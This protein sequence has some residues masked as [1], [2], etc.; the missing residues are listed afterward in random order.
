MWSKKIGIA[1]KNKMLWFSKDYI[2]HQKNMKG[3]I[4]ND[5][6][7]NMYFGFDET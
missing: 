7:Q 6:M 3:I 5:Y 1:N 2:P 4:L